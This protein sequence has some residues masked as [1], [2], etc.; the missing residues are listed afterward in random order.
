MRGQGRIFKRGKKWWIGYYVRGQEF[1][2][3]AGYKEADAKRLL[4]ARLGKIHSGQFLGPQEERITINELLDNLI[5]HLK[6]KGAKS[7]PAFISGLKPIREFF[8]FDR[9]VDIT[10]DRINNYIQ[11]RLNAGKANATINRGV[12]GLRQAFNLAKKEELLNRIPYFPTLKEENARKGFFEKD[13]FEGVVEHLPDYLKDLTRFGYF[14]GWRKA[15]ITSL[16]WGSVDR[17]ANEVWIYTSKNGRGRVLPLEGELQDLIERRW[18]AREVSLKNG[19]TFIC[20]HVFHRNGKKIERFDKTW[21]KACRGAGY[22]GKIFHDLRRT[23]AR[24]MIRAGVS[25][26]VAMDITGHRTISMFLRYNITSED[27]KRKALIAT[28]DHVKSFPSGKTVIPLP[29]VSF[30]NK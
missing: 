1:R 19:Q 8:G 5:I 7:I 13:Q 9:A 10:P 16:T 29:S 26:S 25:Q 27:D 17:I 22:P 2:E 6:T 3:T 14:S 4:K 21:I 30:S 12:T 20:P 24:N 11:A 18:Q 15:E 28:Q 23:A